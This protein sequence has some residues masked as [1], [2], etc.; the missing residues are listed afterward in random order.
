MRAFSIAINLLFENNFF[1]SAGTKLTHEIIKAIVFFKISS[2]WTPIQQ[3]RA[4]QKHIRKKK[5]KEKE[6][7]RYFM[8]ALHNYI[9]NVNSRE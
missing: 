5:G 7:F 1:I 8:E 9:L 2:L 4:K 3:D 6:V